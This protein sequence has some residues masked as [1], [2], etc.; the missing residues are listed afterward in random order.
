MRETHQQSRGAES[1]EISELSE[2]LSTLRAEERET[3]M[4]LTNEQKNQEIISRNFQTEIEAYKIQLNKLKDNIHSHE[5]MREKV[6]SELSGM[7]REI[8]KYSKTRE[9]HRA[10]LE[11]FEEALLS[12]KKQ[13]RTIL[14]AIEQSKLN[15][16]TME[17][18]KRKAGKE[19]RELEERRATIEKRVHFEEQTA[20][21]DIDKINKRYSERQQALL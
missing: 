20:Q 10:S 6:H 1:V 7:K 12:L 11:R 14:E 13:K 17:K 16:R 5:K 19:L 21:D 3:Q 9:E 15:L 8:E 4:A 2:R 18:E